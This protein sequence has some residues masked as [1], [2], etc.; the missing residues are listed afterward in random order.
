ML[1]EAPINEHSGSCLKKC[2]GGTAQQTPPAQWEECGNP[3]PAKKK[4]TA[5]VIFDYT[6]IVISE[7][8]NTKII[9]P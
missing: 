8:G 3:N 7:I 5:N 1:R 4:D 2:S 6:M 9:L